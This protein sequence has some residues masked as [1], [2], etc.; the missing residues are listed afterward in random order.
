MPMS[1][2]YDLAAGDAEY[3]SVVTL[4]REANI[5]DPN[6]ISAYVA[7]R[8]LGHVAKEAAVWINRVL[9]QQVKVT[10]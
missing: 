3:G 2:F 8:M 6:C 1:K 4:L 7:D 9:S 5:H 10:W